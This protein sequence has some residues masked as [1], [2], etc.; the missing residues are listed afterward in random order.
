MLNFRFISGHDDYTPKLVTSYDGYDST[1]FDH[2]IQDS[3]MG[4][5]GV[6]AGTRLPSRYLHLSFEV[7]TDE[8]RE[9]VIKLFSPRR[10]F[11]HIAGRGNVSR[12]ITAYVSALS[13]SQETIYDFHKVKL[14][15]VCPDPYF[16]SLDDYGRDVAL[17]TPQFAFPLVFS[18]SIIAGYSDTVNDIALT[19]EGHDVCG[20]RIR[21]VAN[22]DCS[23][24]TVTNT[25]TGEYIR[26]LGD[27]L[28]GQELEIS[29]VPKQKYARLDGVNVMNRIDRRSSFFSL[30]TGVNHINYDTD[31]GR[32]N[33][34]VYLH[35]KRRFLGI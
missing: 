16:Y 10:Q 15:M 26:F 2:N 14:S 28:Q 5:G 25:D 33:I 9:Y 13:I 3:G 29:T 32:Y 31:T 6:L 7:E 1:D 19:N 12:Q 30:Q 34:S 18:P 35:F 8:E 23:N 11:T 22:N 4:D 27:L 21:I 17:V 24:I 20:L